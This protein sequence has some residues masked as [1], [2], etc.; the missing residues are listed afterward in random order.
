MKLK[1]ACYAA[2]TYPRF[3]VNVLVVYTLQHHCR[4]CGQ[5]FCGNCCQAKVSFRYLVKKNRACTLPFVIIYKTCRI[6]VHDIE[7]TQPVYSRI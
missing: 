2:L 7:H 6:I 3:N 4:R 1:I 5:C